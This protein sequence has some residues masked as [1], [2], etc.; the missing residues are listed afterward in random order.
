VDVMKWLPGVNVKLW[1]IRIGLALAVVSG[2]AYIAYEKGQASERVKVAEE[3]RK[4][5]EIRTVIMM[6]T[7]EKRVPVIQYIER[8]NVKYVT[9]VDSTKRNVDDAIQAAGNR[10]ECRLS[11]AERVQFN[12]LARAVNESFTLP[13]K[14]G[15]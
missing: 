2:T 11:D 12:E 8:E 6:E 5:A 1:L 13:S 3:A 9:R 10:D 15:D 14:R 4:A 7:V